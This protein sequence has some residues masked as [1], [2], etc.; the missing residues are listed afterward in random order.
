ME[1]ELIEQSKRLDRLARHDVDALLELYSDD[2]LIHRLDSSGETMVLDR[3]ALI[4]FF[5][6]RHADTIHLR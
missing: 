1:R 4:A 6:R 5:A 2:F 3:H